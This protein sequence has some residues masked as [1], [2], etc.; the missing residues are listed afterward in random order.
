MPA[1]IWINIPIEVT[2]VGRTL[3]RIIARRWPFS[4]EMADIRNPVYPPLHVRADRRMRRYA[5][6]F[7]GRHYSVRSL[8]CGGSPVAHAASRG[9]GLAKGE[10]ANISHE[11][12]APL[13]AIINMARRAFKAGVYRLSRPA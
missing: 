8:T 5:D 12:R 13:P 11:I 6:T 9:T 10:L 4:K 3:C 2:L 1:E 7:E